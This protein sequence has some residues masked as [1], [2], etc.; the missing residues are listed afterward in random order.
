MTSPCLIKANFHFSVFHEKYMILKE[1]VEIKGNAKKLL[2][3]LEDVKFG[4][5]NFLPFCYYTWN[6][7]KIHIFIS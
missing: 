6:I 1:L 5:L 3:N 2:K 7:N 4:K